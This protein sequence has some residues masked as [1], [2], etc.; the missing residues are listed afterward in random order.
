MIKQLRLRKTILCV[1]LLYEL[2]NR[3]AIVVALGGGGIPP[4]SGQ[5]KFFDAAVILI[6]GNVNFSSPLKIGVIFALFNLS[7]IEL[8]SNDFLRNICN[9]KIKESVH[10]LIIETCM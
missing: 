7:G 2:C 9:G 1:E 6:N 5:N 8:E 4:L 10:I 3:I